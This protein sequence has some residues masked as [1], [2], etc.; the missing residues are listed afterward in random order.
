MARQKSFAP[1]QVSSIWNWFLNSKV[2]FHFEKW[3]FYIKKGKTASLLRI[4]KYVS[5]RKQI[6]NIQNMTMCISW[7]K[8]ARTQNHLVTP[9]CVFNMETERIIY[10]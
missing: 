1:A 6:K 5:I 9:L 2:E 3:T 7:N 8:I 10:H 4:F